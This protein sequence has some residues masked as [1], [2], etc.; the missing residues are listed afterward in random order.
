MEALKWVESVRWFPRALIHPR[1]RNGSSR[2]SN[3]RRSAPA[4]SLRLRNSESTE[5]SQPAS[6]SSRLHAYFQSIRIRTASAACLSLN[7]WAYGRMVTNTRRE[8]S[9]SLLPPSRKEIKQILILIP[10]SSFI[11]HP[12][13]GVPLGKDRMRYTGRFFRDC[14]NE[15]WMH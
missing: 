8:A 7:P 5:K 14:W 12:H 13:G 3:R 6:V 15:L 1:A 2:R 10:G 9:Q 11:T 4:G